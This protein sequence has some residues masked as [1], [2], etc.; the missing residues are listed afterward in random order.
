MLSLDT[1]SNSFDR[2]IVHVWTFTPHRWHGQPESEKQNFFVSSR[3][4]LSA[5]PISAFLT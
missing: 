3:F 5:F 1:Y 4:L 2:M